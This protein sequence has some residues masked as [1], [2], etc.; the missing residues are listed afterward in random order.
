MLITICLQ[1]KFRQK[2]L[3]FS[4]TFHIK[5]VNLA[6]ESLILRITS[7]TRKMEAIET[8]LLKPRIIKIT[9]FFIFKILIK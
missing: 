8:L 7:D 4:H 9:L 2:I 5:I 1:K 3:D 6:S